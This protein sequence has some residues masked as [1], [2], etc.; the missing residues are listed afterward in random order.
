MI[1]LGIDPALGN[2]GWALVAKE[3]T[4]LKY[5][6]SGTIKTHSKD[7]IHNRLA[8]INSTLEK[9][10]LKYQ[11]NIAA[12]EE[13][14]IN[15]NSVTSL[16]LGY[17]RGAIMSLIG[18]YNLNMQEFKPNTVKKT[19]TGY[20]HAKKEQILYMIKHLIPGTDLITNSDEADAVALAYTSL[21]TKKY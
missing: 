17:A 8:F 5:L 4:K 18:R 12:I 16:K 19:V 15:T 7:E 14:F 1:V 6:A 3:Y 21:V 11:P 13:T 10:I 9:V 2:L 20:G